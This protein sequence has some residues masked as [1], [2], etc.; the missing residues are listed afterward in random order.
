M[1]QSAKFILKKA[2]YISMIAGLIIIGAGFA[3]VNFNPYKLQTKQQ[4]PFEKKEESYAID[5]IS[6]LKIESYH[7]D[8]TLTPSNDD[9]FHIQYSENEE[10]PV[11]LKIEQNT[12]SFQRVPQAVQISWFNFE[13]DINIPITIEVPQQYTGS[14][15]LENTYGFVDINHMTNTDVFI[16]SQHGPIQMNTIQSDTLQVRGS[17]SDITLTDM[18]IAKKLNLSNEHAAIT[19]DKLNA[20][21]LKVTGSYSDI[22]L[23]DVTLAQALSLE[24]EHGTISLERMKA[25]ALILSSSYSD[26]SFQEVSLQKNIHID[27]E[28]SAL[29]LGSLRAQSLDLTSD[30]GDIEGKV[31]QIEQAVDISIEHSAINI[32]NLEAT[33]LQL[34]SSY[35]DCIITN[36][37]AQ[38]IIADLYHGSISTILK[39]S[40]DDFH[41]VSEASHG[42]NML[43]TQYNKDGKQK[44]QI[45]TDYGDIDI[46]FQP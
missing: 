29:N 27:N 45:N 12:L 33:D 34:T 7:S 37:T 16:E 11:D 15:S 35:G 24:N 9:Q 21:E 44:L 30:Y 1:N 39:G 17:Y 10:Y 40:L 3:M 5:A 4:L 28:H 22:R 23:K 6:K 20:D 32:A 31:F 38:N 14:L 19:F 2:P 42:E 18:T 8:I 36:T 43:P 46:S 13:H 25:D 26:T 41:I